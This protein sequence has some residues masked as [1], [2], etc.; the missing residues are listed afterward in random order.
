MKKTGIYTITNIINNKIYLGSASNS[1]YQRWGVHRYDLKNNKH[2][3]KYLQRAVNKHGIENF[4][5]EILDECEPEFCL[6]AEQWWINMLNVCNPKFGYNLCAVAGNTYG[7]K[8]S[9]EAKKKM[10]DSRKGKKFTEAHKLALSKAGKGKNAGE[11]S[12][13]WGK[14]GK[15]SRVFGLKHTVETLKIISARSSGINNP[16]A[17]AVNQFDKNGNFIKRWDYALLAAKE[18]LGLNDGNNISSCCRGRLKTSG[19]FIWKYADTIESDF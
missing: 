19:G 7:R 2:S 6:S 1:F 5:F 8:A 15:E 3:N 4:K 10:S 17:R 9:I 12:P 16:R 18:L 14:F 13:N 11:K